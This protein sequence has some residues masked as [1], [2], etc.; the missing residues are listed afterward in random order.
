MSCGPWTVEE[1]NMCGAGAT[2]KGK[3]MDGTGGATLPG[4]SGT[5]S[6]AGSD[7]RRSLLASLCTQRRTTLMD[8]LDRR[9]GL[10]LDWASTTFGDSERRGSGELLED[11]SSSVGR[12]ISSGRDEGSGR[13]G[14]H[15]F[16]AWMVSNRVCR[17]SL[18]SRNW[19]ACSRNLAIYLACSSCIASIS[20]C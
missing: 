19:F 8:R 14:P 18:S 15:N 2:L 16:S 9:G 12:S 11:N 10:F 6:R 4:R 13:G 7:W 17:H 1:K 3:Y 20:W 5:Y